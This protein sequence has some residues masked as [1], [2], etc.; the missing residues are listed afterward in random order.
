MVS[1]SSSIVPL[2]ASTSEVLASQAIPS[3]P[4][5]SSFAASLPVAEA[6][7]STSAYPLFP[8]AGRLIGYGDLVIMQLVRR[9]LWCLQETRRLL[10]SSPT[11]IPDATRARPPPPSRTLHRQSRESLVPVMIEAGAKAQ[12]RFGTYEHDRLVGVPFGSRV[13]VLA[14]AG[15]GQTLTL[16]APAHSRARP[17]AVRH[18]QGLCLCQCT[19]SHQQGRAL[20]DRSHDAL[21]LLRPTPELWTLALPHRTQILYA[22]DI[23]LILQ[24]LSVRP[25]S[26][27]V[28]AGT[29]S[30]SFS[31]AVARTVS[32]HGR[33]HSFEFHETRAQKAQCVPP[34]LPPCPD[35]RPGADRLLFVSCDLQGR[36][37]GAWHGLARVLHVAERLQGGLPAR[38]RRR[39]RC[40][41]RCLA[42]CPSFQR[43]LTDRHLACARI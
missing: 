18:G 29:G 5:A 39:C 22:A 27:V 36:V 33:L 26:T 7:T 24:Q 2:S 11:D 37:Q 4:V 43:L 34:C 10:N 32:P 31:H 9:R 14:R 41:H 19:M 38:G 20:A 23:A 21:Q 8:S 15:E 40:D 17:G 28:E 12:N 13:R 42:V 3:V 1:P 35:M 30:G 25:G 16:S 6:S